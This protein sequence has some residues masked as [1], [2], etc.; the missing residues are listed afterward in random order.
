M[1][2]IVRIFAALLYYIFLF[3][4]IVVFID[5]FGDLSQ[6]NLYVSR[7][8]ALILAII[9]SYNTKITLP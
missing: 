3:G 9:G 7:I 6:S 8:I 1:K 4:L 5:I 2:T